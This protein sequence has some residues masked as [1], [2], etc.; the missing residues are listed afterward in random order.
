VDLE[1]LAEGRGALVARDEDDPAPAVRVGLVALASRRSSRVLSVS[2]S[3]FV[4]T[5]I[6]SICFTTF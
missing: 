2:T 3:F 6:D 4:A 5:P 1:R